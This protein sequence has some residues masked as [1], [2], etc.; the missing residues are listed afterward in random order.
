MTWF[1]QNLS[2]SAWW[3]PR[4]DNM[5]LVVVYYYIIL[6]L[7]DCNSKVKVKLATWVKGDQKAPFSIATKLRCRGGCYSIPWTAPL[8]PLMLKVKQGSIIFWVYGTTQPGIEPWSPGSL[9]NTLLIR[10]ITWLF[11]VICRK[12]VKR[13]NWSSI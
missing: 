13:F 9:V 5:K 6:Y 4:I 2:I 12:Y 3:L 8:Y 1:L 7:W 11:K 10:P